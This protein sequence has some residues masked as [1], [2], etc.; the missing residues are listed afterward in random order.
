MLNQLVRYAYDHKLVAEPGFAPRN[1]RWAIELAG[2]GRFLNVVSLGQDKAGQPFAKCPELS[3]PEL[4]GLGGRGAQFLLAPCDVVA[5]LMKDD[6]PDAERQKAEQKHD[7]FVARLRDAASALPSLANAAAA[8]SD[9]DRLAQIRQRLSEQSA[10]PTDKATLL[11]GGA[12]PVEDEAW[13]DWWRA[14]RSSLSARAATRNKMTCFATG[15]LAEP[16]RTHPKIGGLGDVGGSSMGS[17]LVGYDKD[18]FE[19]YG[20]KQSANGAVS[21]A[22]A[23]AYRA[24]LN[25]LLDKRSERLAGMKI[26]YWFD[27]LV[28]TSDDP[29]E[30]L[31]LERSRSATD[32]AAA[33]NRARSLLRAVRD[34]KNDQERSL[35]GARYFALTL[36]GAAGR[37]MARD[38]MEGSFEELAES[39]VAWFDDLSIVAYDGFRLASEPKLERVITCLLPSKPLA[40]KYDDWIKPVGAVRVPLWTA[41]LRKDAP[42]PFSVLGHIVL[43]H[44]A[45]VLKGELA[46][47]EATRGKA[48]AARGPNDTAADTEQKEQTDGLM[49]SLLH[50]RM[51]LIK[52][53]HNRTNRR[54][55]GFVMKDCY[56]NEDHPD[57]AYHCGRLMSVLA[58]LQQAAL[59]DVGAGVIQRFYAAASKTPALILGRLTTTSQFHI[60]KLAG[61]SPGLAFW[62]EN[63]IADIWCRIKDNPPTTL[64]LE[65]QSLF[66]LGYYQQ[67]AFDRTKKP[68]SDGGDTTP[69]GNTA[70]NEETASA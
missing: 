19:S 32:E 20:L 9:P 50:A 1:A 23:F 47:I 57:A 53:Y 11:V 56:L 65:K 5:L 55:G 38:W 64:S 34:P 15:E 42:I 21:E 25:H 66:A 27:R 28:P 12:F 2:D 35:A 39:L 3:Q 17:P 63:K 51:A 29:F 41:A 68:S 62:Y 4:K 59:G 52:A 43:Q 24:A 54:N 22:A 10:K 14:Y 30:L 26:A 61:D 46:K 37:V 69:G 8:L 13:H 48:K 44:T 36:S 60:G 49:V 6:V 18:A 58:R 7:F 45:F 31:L 67:M 33:L 16:A 40:Q 70:K